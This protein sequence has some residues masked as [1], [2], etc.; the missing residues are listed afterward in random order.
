MVILTAFCAITTKSWIRF[1]LKLA[2]GRAPMG[3]RLFCVYHLE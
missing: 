2:R 1:G 3:I